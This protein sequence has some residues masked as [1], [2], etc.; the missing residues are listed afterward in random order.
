[1]LRGRGIGMIVA[2]DVQYEGDRA[3]AAAVIFDNWTDATPRDTITVFIEGV[4][5]YEAG[6][7]YKREL[8]C[9]LKALDAVEAKHGRPDLLIVDAYVNLEPGHPGLGRRLFDA[10]GIPVVG[11]AKTRFH[12]AE[13]EP[14]MR[15]GS[16]NPL[17]VTSVGVVNM[18][19][20]V[21]QMAG[22]YRN[23]TLLKLA[24]RLA[25]EGAK[26]LR[27]KEG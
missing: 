9:L 4:A 2:L 26:E 21:V 19:P 7:F 11:V 10:V 24:D 3:A 12:Q 15:G 25:R 17:Y 13:A 23:P 20:H 14:V 18:A 27:V 1:M 5:P 6:S 22:E 16:G 8:P